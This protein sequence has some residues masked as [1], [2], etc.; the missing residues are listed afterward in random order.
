MGATRE[1]DSREEIGSE[2][3]DRV[4]LAIKENADSSIF[5]CVRSHPACQISEQAGTVS[6]AAP[7]VPGGE[8]EAGEEGGKDPV[9]ALPVS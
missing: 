8:T 5:L 6:A 3:Q 7:C 2:T 1:R 4:Q 9:P